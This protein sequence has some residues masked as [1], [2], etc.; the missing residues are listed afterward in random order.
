VI[1]GERADEPVREL[2]PDD[3]LEALPPAR[4]RLHRP[5][6]PDAVV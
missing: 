1:P 4:P 6:D 5:G 2:V 3:V